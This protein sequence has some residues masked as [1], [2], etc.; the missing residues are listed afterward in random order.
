MLVLLFPGYISAQELLIYVAD[1]NAKQVLS[2]DGVTNDS[3][4]AEAP[5][6]AIFEEDGYDVQIFQITTLSTADQSVIDMLDEADLIYIGRRVASANFQSP[7][8][9]IWNNLF[10][11]IMTENMWALRGGTNMRMN[12]FN[13]DG[14]YT[15]TT[16]EDSA[17]VYATIELAQ[18][19]DEIFEGLDE[20]FEDVDITDTIAWWYGSHN[21]ID[22]A[23]DFGNGTLMATASTAAGDKPIWVRFEDGDEFYPGSVDMP[24]GE[25][26]YFGLGCERDNLY[27]YYSRYTEV[28]KEIFLREAARLSG[29]WRGESDVKKFNYGAVASMVYFNPVIQKLVVE[30]DNLNRM[31]VFDISGKLIYA[32]P[33][34]SNKL[35]VDLGFAESGIYLVRLFDNNNNFSTN[36]IIK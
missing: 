5:T 26:V 33:A 20:L 18:I 7:E 17:L 12:W 13:S 4:L 30:M 2:P 24:A 8:K 36:K 9:E 3:V 16:I 34:K 25:R 23:G 14:I 6:I 1:T 31:E 15:N 19:D 21:T 27:Q 28:S 22:P 10:P 35:Y 32:A 11:P 29:H